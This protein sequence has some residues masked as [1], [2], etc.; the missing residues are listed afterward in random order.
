MK[1]SLHRTT[2]RSRKMWDL[3][4]NLLPSLYDQLQL[5]LSVAES[6][7]YVSEQFCVFVYHQK[8]GKYKYVHI[9]IHV[10]QRR[11]SCILSLS[12]T[13]QTSNHGA[14]SVEIRVEADDFPLSS[15]C[16]RVVHGILKSG[17]S[18]VVLMDRTSCVLSFICFPG[19]GIGCIL[20]ERH[21]PNYL[22][23]FQTNKHVS[24]ILVWTAAV[25]KWGWMVIIVEK[26]SQRSPTPVHW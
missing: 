7:L 8:Q 26:S 13:Q 10:K 22:P 21:Y 2:G 14:D 18:I 1:T 19:G 16:V 9:Y 12:H 3:L 5:P 4:F 20:V 23:S 25:G 6:V 17:L 24:I 15:F 11:R